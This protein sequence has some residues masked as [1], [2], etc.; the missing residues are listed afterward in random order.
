M[1]KIIGLLALLLLAGCVSAPP[2]TLQVN[3]RVG[4]A[5][6]IGVVSERT[7]GEVIY[8]TFN[9]EE[10][11]GAHLAGPLLID[12]FAASADLGPGDALVAGQEAGETVFCTSGPILRVAGQGPTSRVCL[13]DTDADGRFDQWRSPDGPPARRNWADLEAPAAYTTGSSM[14]PTGGGFKYQLLYQGLSSGVISLLYREYADNL[15]R[16]AFQQE[17][18]YTLAKNGSTEISFRTTRIEIHAAD[19]NSIRYT[20]LR[21]LGVP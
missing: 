9:Y 19:N 20:V 13:K 4:E 6:P 10:W 3:R 21:G 2:P 8:E 12:V 16:P 7:V 17:L 14:A 11:S 1:K 15:I 18:S 5:P